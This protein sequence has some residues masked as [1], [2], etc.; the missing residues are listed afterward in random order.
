MQ[1]GIHPDYT[2]E[3]YLEICAAVKAACPACTCTPSRRSRSGRARAR[4]ACRCRASSPAEGGR[5]RLAARHRG[6]GAGRRGARR[7]LPGQDQ[8]GQWLEV[9]ET[10][11]GRACARPRPSCSATSTGRALGA[12]PAARARAAGATG[13]FTEFVPLPFVHMEAPIYLKGRARGPDL[14]RGAADARG[15]AL[16]LH[17][18][19]TN[20]QASGSRWAPTAC[21]CLP[22][23]STIVGGTL[24]NETHHARRRRLARAGAR[25]AAMRAL[26]RRAAR[27]RAS[28]RRCTRRD[29]RH[30]ARARAGL[31]ARLVSARVPRVQP[32]RAPLVRQA[33]LKPRSDPSRASSA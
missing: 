26:V 9:M 1:G 18:H 14:P 21:A 12:P 23:A 25:P 17:P 31:R 27:R 4:S 3:T 7:A 13:G 29:A 28:A 11:H 24:M 19:I 16:A 22:P 5:A 2:G 10:A 6:G 30:A 32:A 8:H 20:M 33:C 15:G